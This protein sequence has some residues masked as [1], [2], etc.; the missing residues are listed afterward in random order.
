MFF[1]C[2]LLKSYPSEIILLY[3]TKELHF[4]RMKNWL[5]VNFYL[6]MPANILHQYALSLIKPSFN[7]QD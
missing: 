1:Q 3:A 6:S 7:H 5:K 4:N 2:D